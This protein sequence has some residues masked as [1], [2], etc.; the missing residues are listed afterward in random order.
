MHGASS[1][2]STKDP[3]EDDDPDDTV[4]RRVVDVGPLR[5]DGLF[6][7]SLVHLPG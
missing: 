4:N 3:D 7:A 6:D 2:I 1:D 5:F